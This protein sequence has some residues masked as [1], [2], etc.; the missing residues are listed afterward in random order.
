M[1]EALSHLYANDPVNAKRIET[2]TLFTGKNT[3]D[4]SGF[5]DRSI[6]Y[7]ENFQLLDPVHWARFVN[8]FRIHS[9]KDGKGGGWK[10]EFWGKMMRGATF[11]Y[12]YTRNEK[13]YKILTDT[14]E[15]MLSTIDGLGRI[16]TYTPDNEFIFWDVW[17]RKYVL[18][19][20]QYFMEICTDENLK[21]RIVD[22]ME[23]QVNY[24]MS[25]VGPAS[26]GKTPITE[27]SNFW[28]GLNSSSLLEPVVRLYDITGKKEYLDYAAYI[29]SEGG[30]SISNVFELAFED[31]CDPYQYPMTKAYE[32]I[33]CFE[34]L[35]EYYRATGIEKY[36][37]AVL[38]FGRRLGK[39]DITIIGSAGCTH[40]N[41]DHAAARQTDTAYQG[42]MQET[43]VTVTWMKFCWQLLMLS[44]DVQYADYFEQS[45]YNAYL[46]AVNTEKITDEKLV[47]ERCADAHPEALPFDSY[48]S[49]LPNTRGRGIGGLQFMPDNHYYGCC[50]CIG[51]AGCGMIHKEGVMLKKNGIC[52]NLYIP[53]TVKTLTPEANEI[54]LKFDTAYPV[55]G[56]IKITLEMNKDEAFDLDLR[57]PAWSKRNSLTV[58]G[59]ETDVSVGYNTISRTWK[60]GDTV[61][62]KLDM[63]TELLRPQSNPRDILFRRVDWGHNYVVP[64]VVTESPDARFHVALRRGPVVL[65]RDARLGENVDEPVD[66]LFDEDGYVALSPC[67]SAGFDTIEEFTVPEKGGKSFKVI[68]YSSAGKT[69]NEDSRYGCWL[70]TR[71]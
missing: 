5:I 67:K 38:N 9:D 35:L 62:L 58:C 48:S 20:M 3:T 37:I 15:D 68:D 26:E 8:Q 32:L 51:A 57:V 40:E 49:L 14:V 6:R 34:G 39:S 61:T 50:A 4:Y 66:I 54:T 56:E 36:K 24:I 55:D 22:S 13:L 70:P 21:A 28:R 47:H 27:T 2:D 1:N 11:T 69:W 19:G 31:K 64:E 60:N 42:I 10:G 7:I 43:C 18:L 25:K 65:A 17:S 52:V 71:K 44:G 33:S 12:T 41:L 16:S 59:E 30:T 23:K 63:R 46:G 29:V 53:G 45:L